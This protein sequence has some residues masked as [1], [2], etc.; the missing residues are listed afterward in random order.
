MLKDQ[1]DKWIIN[2][3]TVTFFCFHV[4]WK[5]NTCRLKPLTIVSCVK[6]FHRAHRYYIDSIERHWHDAQ[7]LLILWIEPQSDPLVLGRAHIY[8]TDCRM[9]TKAWHSGAWKNL[10]IWQWFLEKARERDCYFVKI[11][12]M[13]LGRVPKQQHTGHCQSAQI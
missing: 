3:K 10:E 4:M 1:R 8:E 7:I 5:R 6:C 11:C 13:R 9:K 12:T 2:L